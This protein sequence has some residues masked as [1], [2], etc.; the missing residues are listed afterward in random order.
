MNENETKNREPVQLPLWDISTRIQCRN[1]IHPELPQRLKQDVHD[2][3]RVKKLREVLETLK[4]R[5]VN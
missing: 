5:D 4:L 2:Q 1:Q 3:A